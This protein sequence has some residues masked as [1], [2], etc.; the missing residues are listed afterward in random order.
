MSQLEIK[1]GAA[2]QK[3]IGTMGTGT[4]GDPFFYINADFNLEVRKGNVFKHE[5][6]NIIGHKYALGTAEVVVSEVD[7]GDDLNQS[8]IDATPAT[9]KIS[10]VD[11]GDTSGGAGLRT[12]TLS[13][14]DSS[15]DAQSETITMNGTT[16]VVS[17]N[18]YSAILGLRGLTWGATTWNEGIIYCGSGTV[19][20]GKPAVL[21][22][23]M[24]FDAARARGGNKG[25]SAYYVVPNGKTFYGFWL[26]STVGTSGKDV[27]VHIQVSS[28]GV[29]WVT[30]EVFEYESGS[31]I[32]KPIHGLSMQAAGT[33]IRITAISSAASTNM[34]ASLDGYLIT[35]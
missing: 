4:S 8:T 17:A 25:L 34:A 24:G 26:T 21:F 35:T 3:F 6:V 7:A 27:Q 1:N 10:S 14:L 15:G 28:D 30:E 5:I 23:A 18:T 12:L 2:V 20:A 16:E 29:N 11:T 31:V 13:G 33:H 32:S 22:F 9:V 19:T